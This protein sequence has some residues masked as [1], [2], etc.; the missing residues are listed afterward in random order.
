MQ[1]PLFGPGSHWSVGRSAFIDIRVT[2]NALFGAH[3]LRQRIRSWRTLL[4]LDIAV[5]VFVENR[6]G[7]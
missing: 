2:V 3:Y 5:F 6:R 4:L 1:Y 7:R